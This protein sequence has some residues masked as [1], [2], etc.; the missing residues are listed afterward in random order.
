MFVWS[1]RKLAWIEAQLKTSSAIPGSTELG[2]ST[3]TAFKP[4][5]CKFGKIQVR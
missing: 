1:K 4:E 2:C 3:L 5:I